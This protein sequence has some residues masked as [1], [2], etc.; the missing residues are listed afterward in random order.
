MRGAVQPGAV[1]RARDWNA[2]H[3]IGTPCIVNVPSTPRG[4]IGGE[5]ES[6]AFL[7]DAGEAVV[8]VAC[9]GGVAT[10]VV[11]LELVR[12]LPVRED[13]VL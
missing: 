10:I 12:F 13:P 4:D 6:L 11:P 1:D 3:P 2:A 7:N 5:L 9:F 8:R